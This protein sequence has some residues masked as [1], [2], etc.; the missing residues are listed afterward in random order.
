MA[1]HKRRIP[2]TKFPNAA[3]VS[4]ERALVKMIDELG[5]EALKLFDQ[6]VVPNLMRG[7]DAE[8]RND[9][10]FGGIKKMFNALKRAA[11]QIFH[12]PHTTSSQRTSTTRAERA[13]EEFVNNVERASKVNLDKQVKAA[14]I[15]TVLAEPWL[16]GFVKKRVKDNVSYIKNLE[17]EAYERIENVVNEHISRNSAPKAIREAIKEQKD[18]SKSRAKFLAVDQSGSIF[19]QINAE[20]HQRMGLEKFIWD[21][22]GDERVRDTHRKLDGKVFEYAAPPTVGKR[23]VLPGEDYRCRCVAIPVFDDE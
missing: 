5:K 9:F 1:K 8:F 4:Y 3:T 13:A 2:R 21:T 11:N 6:H 14:G 18:I 10:I 15:A 17:E 19:G 7:D 12:S 22:S 16:D 20:R 23:E